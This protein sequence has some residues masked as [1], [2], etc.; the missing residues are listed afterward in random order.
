LFKFSKTFFSSKKVIIIGLNLIVSIKE[1][2]KILLSSFVLFLLGGTAHGQQI[3]GQVVDLLTG[4]PID[5]ARVT[6]QNLN[7]GTLDSV[8]TTD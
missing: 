3:S 6:I 2:L 8:C 7:D 4:T 5:Q 1:P